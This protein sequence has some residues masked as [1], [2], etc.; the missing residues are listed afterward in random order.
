MFQLIFLFPFFKV[1]IGSDA[2]LELNNEITP[3]DIFPCNFFCLEIYKKK[4][5]IFFY[6]FVQISYW[7][8]CYFL[9]LIVNSSVKY[10]LTVKFVYLAACN[11]DIQPWFHFPQESVLFLSIEWY[12]WLALYKPGSFVP[13][14]LYLCR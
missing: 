14:C 2:Q 13:L 10:I 5:D 12:E 8:F 4:L 7:C 1:M 11:C 9:I 3:C 6:I